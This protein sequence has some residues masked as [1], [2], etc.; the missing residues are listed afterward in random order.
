[1]KKPFTNE[2]WDSFWTTRKTNRDNVNISSTNGSS[3][4]NNAPKNNAPK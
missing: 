2:E 4:K 3:S 1:M